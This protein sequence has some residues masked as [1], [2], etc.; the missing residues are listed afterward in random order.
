M[1]IELS[2]TSDGLG[3]ISDY[4]GLVN[5][6]DLMD[7]CEFRI[8]NSDN[9]PGRKY[10]IADFTKAENVNFTSQ[11]IIQNVRKARSGLI[12]FIDDLIYVAIVTGEEQYGM[13]RMWTTMSDNDRME[14]YIVHSYDEA[15][16]LIISHLDRLGLNSD[17]SWPI[18]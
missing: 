13:M 17:I 18:S 6:K 1:A 14:T 2:F 12:P 9:L 4:N 15:R 7:A 3:I 11:G 10:N 5:D 8:A 16:G